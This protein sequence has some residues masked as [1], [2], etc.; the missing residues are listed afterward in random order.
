MHFTV[1]WYSAVVQCSEMRVL[2]NRKLGTRGREETSSG[3]CLDLEH[4]ATAKID[5]RVAMTEIDGRVSMT[6]IDGRVSIT[7]MSSIIF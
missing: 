6:D 1:V 4:L 2:A 3:C 5:G 7:K